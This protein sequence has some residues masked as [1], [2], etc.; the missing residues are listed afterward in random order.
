M[1]LVVTLLVL[2]GG[3]SLQI[4]ATKADVAA[5]ELCCAKAQEQAQLNKQATTYQVKTLERVQVQI[6]NMDTEQRADSKNIARLL[7]R[8]RV[9]P[10]ARTK[11]KPVP[12]PAAV[13]DF[14]PMTP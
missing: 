9:E 2:G 13:P 8:F 12:K 4:Y 7:D 11:P 10:V 3:V 14:K 5:V 6:E 1:G